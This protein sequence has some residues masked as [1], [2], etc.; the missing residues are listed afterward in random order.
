MAGPSPS[1]GWAV[2]WKQVAALNIKLEVAA[3][4]AKSAEA[5]GP[6]EQV[7]DSSRMAKKTSWLCALQSGLQLLSISVLLMAVQGK[8]GSLWALIVC[9]KAAASW[10]AHRG[11]ALLVLWALNRITGLCLRA[12]VWT[13]HLKTGFSLRA[14]VWSNLVHNCL[15][16]ALASLTQSTSINP[17]TVSVFGS[18]DP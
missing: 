1:G 8:D 5:G 4:A 13:F 2:H 16:D 14:Q 10:C 11:S 3:V 15:L 18:N 6:A 7:G 9:L 12:L 17:K